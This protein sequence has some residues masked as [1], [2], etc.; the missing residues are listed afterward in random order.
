MAT[1]VARADEHASPHAFT[2][3]SRPAAERPH[4]RPNLN[5]GASGDIP[6]WV[7]HMGLPIWVPGHAADTAESESDSRR[8]VAVAGAAAPSTRCNPRDY[9]CTTVRSSH[10][11]GRGRRQAARTASFL[12]RGF[13]RAL[14]LREFRCSFR[15]LRRQRA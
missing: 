2:F 8:R 4:F 6:I 14:Q 9:T 5:V 15:C 1:L 3:G 13:H 10:H 7:I 11:R 12:L